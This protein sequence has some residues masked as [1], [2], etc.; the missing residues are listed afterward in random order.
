VT[1]PRVHLLILSRLNRVSEIPL[2]VSAHFQRRKWSHEIGRTQRTTSQASR[3]CVMNSMC[4]SQYLGWI[5]PRIQ[6]WTAISA[7]GEETFSNRICDGRLNTLCSIRVSRL[8]LCSYLFAF[9]ALKIRR[10][11]VKLI[12]ELE[13]MIR[14]DFAEGESHSLNDWPERINE[15]WPNW[16]LKQ[17]DLS[18]EGLVYWN[19]ILKLGFP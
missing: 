1:I 16:M 8:S 19:L 9:T 11:G 2:L 12:V 17:W 14:L 7:N 15:K 13:N 10:D 4:S 3:T 6:M 18:Q 5:A